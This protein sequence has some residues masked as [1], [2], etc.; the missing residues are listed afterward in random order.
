MQN[1][2]IDD[3]SLKV[4]WKGINEFHF[5]CLKIISA[6][7]ELKVTRALFLIGAI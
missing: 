5:I 1:F 3:P 7:D 4:N 2:D 6:L